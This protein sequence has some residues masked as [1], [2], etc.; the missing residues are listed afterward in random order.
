VITIAA[1][2]ISLAAEDGR[3]ART[4]TVVVVPL[5]VFEDHDRIVN[6]DADDQRHREQQTVSIVKFSSFIAK[7]RHQQRG[8]I[9]TITTSALRHERRKN[10][11]ATPVKIT[12]SISVCSTPS[13]C[14][15]VKSADVQHAELHVGNCA[16][17][18][19][20]A[21]CPRARPLLRSRRRFLDVERN[22]R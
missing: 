11:I 14:C 21:S 3:G 19:G 16:S 13:N 18:A 8:G 9:A 20:S 1:D 17:M 12:P 4:L 2:P 5:D 15:S 6:Q 22:G 10:S 7:E